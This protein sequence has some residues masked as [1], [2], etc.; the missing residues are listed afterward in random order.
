MILVVFAF[1]RRVRATLI[2][3]AAVPVSIIATFRFMY[4]A[5]STIKHP[6]NNVGLRPH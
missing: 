1:L 5:A 6:P 4:L 2:P 3:A